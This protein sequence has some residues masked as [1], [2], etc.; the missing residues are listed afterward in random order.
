MEQG[1]IPRED[2]ETKPNRRQLERAKEAPLPSDALPKY[3]GHGYVPTENAVAFAP[4]DVAPTTPLEITGISGVVLEARDL[5]ATRAFYE[6]IFRDV[7]GAWHEGTR[8]LTLQAEGQR[9]EFVPRPRPRTIAHAGQ[10]VAYRVR[11][12]RLP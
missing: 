9:V 11:A 5:G 1:T 10:H 12:A 8:R 2:Q 4:A 7:A 3:G 6:P